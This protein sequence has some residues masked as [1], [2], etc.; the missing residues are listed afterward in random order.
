MTEATSPPEGRSGRQIGVRIALSIALAA[1]FV[2]AL[3]PYLQ[4]IPPDLSIP[5]WLI[6]A[7]LLTLVPYHVLRAG[8]WQFLL[9]PLDPPRWRE[10]LAIG[11]A[12]YFWIAI[13]PFRLGELARPV[14]LSQR[15]R[16]PITSSLAT[17]VIE[18]VVDG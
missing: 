6:P 11:L 1:G 4:T 8:R 5:G 2:F 9:Q 16:I 10:T 14:F 18:R 13:L 17:V 15:S 7:Y 3:R 12:G